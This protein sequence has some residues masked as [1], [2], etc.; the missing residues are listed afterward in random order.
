M[1][2]K[3]FSL[4]FAAFALGASSASAVT[5]TAG[6][7]G[8]QNG[9]AA[10]TVTGGNVGTVDFSW[11][12]TP[13]SAYQYFTSASV[14]NLFLDSYLPAAGTPAAVQTT[15]WV[16]K[17][18]V[19]GVWA[20]LTTSTNNCAAA[21]APVRGSCDH[22]ATAAYSGSIAA[23]QP[24]NQLS[25]GGQSLFGAGTY[26]LGVYD[27]AQ[28]VSAT[29]SFRVAAVPLPATG[30]AL[31]AGLGGLAALGARRRRNAA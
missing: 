15:G 10:M 25:A 24:G 27:S 9:T 11:T 19:G 6:A 26:L 17:Q 18:L 31:I 16:L 21:V 14:F 22:I 1:R 23:S 29:A 12:N 20:N 8:G 3:L 13:A 30:L 7:Y 28:P 5:I 2:N 4:A